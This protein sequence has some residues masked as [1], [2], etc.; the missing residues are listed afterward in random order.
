MAYGRSWV[1]TRVNWGIGVE[2]SGMGGNDR[3]GGFD[4][5]EQ[6]NSSELKEFTS[7]DGEV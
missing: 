2:N 5:I 3:R 7:S 1:I 6:D 4:A